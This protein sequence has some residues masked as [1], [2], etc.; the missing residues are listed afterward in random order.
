MDDIE[1]NKKS[2]VVP[3]YLLTPRLLLK[4]STSPEMSI[5]SGSVLPSMLMLSGAASC[6]PETKERRCPRNSLTVGRFL[7]CIA[8]SM[9]EES[10]G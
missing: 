3:V 9:C 10:A 2:V 8:A 1:Q 5:G 4:V 7:R 6:L